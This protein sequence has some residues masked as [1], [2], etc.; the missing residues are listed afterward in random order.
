MTIFHEKFEIK[1]LRL[2]T[3]SFWWLQVN[4]FILARNNFLQK[5]LNERKAENLKNRIR[6]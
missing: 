3:E 2:V 5:G 4:V 1:M 6:M